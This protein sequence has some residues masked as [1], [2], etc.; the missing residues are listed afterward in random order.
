MLNTDVRTDISAENP[1]EQPTGHISHSQDIPEPGEQHYDNVFYTGPRYPPKTRSVESDQ[2]SV[3]EYPLDLSMR[4]S[5]SSNSMSES[6]AS[7]KKIPYIA[8]T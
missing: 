7:N 4:S 8:V 3:Q 6:T 1:Q 2:S 5:M